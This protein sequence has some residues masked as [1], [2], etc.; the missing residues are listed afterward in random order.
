MKD[1]ITWSRKVL[2]AIESLVI[3]DDQ[4]K[5]R[6][7]AAGQAAD[8][9][10]ATGDAD[11]YKWEMAACS[12]A[13]YRVARHKDAIQLGRR[14]LAA[15]REDDIAE[16]SHERRAF[17]WCW[18]AMSQFQLGQIKESQASLK[19]ANEAARGTN[20][21]NLPKLLATATKLIEPASARP[22]SKPASSTTPKTPPAAAPS[23]P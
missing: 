6:Y 11:L 8:E 16:D 10:L 1:D 15:A 17:A 13:Y 20:S 14:A 9:L 21:A 4:P 12:G 2:D 22:P 3:Q 23:T 7:R 18:I 5:D 19:S